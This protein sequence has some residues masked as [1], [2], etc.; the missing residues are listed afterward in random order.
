LFARAPC[1]QPTRFWQRV[2]DAVRESP[3]RCQ[4][5][6]RRGHGRTDAASPSPEIKSRAE[7]SKTRHRR[8]GTPA[9]GGGLG[10]EERPH[11][12]TD[13]AAASPMCRADAR[14]HDGRSTGMKRR[15]PAALPAA[16]QGSGTA[17][18]ARAPPS[19]PAQLLSSSRSR[20]RPA[21]GRRP[22]A[23]VAC[24]A[25]SRGSRWPEP[26]NYSKSRRLAPTSARTA[27]FVA[28][29]GAPAP[30]VKIVFALLY[31]KVRTKFHGNRGEG[32]IVHRACLLAGETMPGSFIH[33]SGIGPAL[34]YGL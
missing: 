19:H 31:L 7:Q 34:V 23:R 12:S 30:S 5:R 24:A 3:A 20:A 21:R 32:S 2:R 10:L 14:K 25:C 29:H 13:E 27:R 15:T 33:L 1:K 8:E 6:S 22:V 17:H 16:P 4:I 26:Q 18:R 9:G 28:R 11:V